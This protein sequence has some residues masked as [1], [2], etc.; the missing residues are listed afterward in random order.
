MFA[1]AHLGSGDEARRG[2]YRPGRRAKQRRA[3]RF[4]LRL[5]LEWL[6]DRVVPAFVGPVSTPIAAGTVGMVVA[7]F[8][9]DGKLDV[10][11]DNT[12][13]DQVDVMLGNGDGTFQPQVAYSAGTQAPTGLVAGDF[14]GDGHVDLGVIGGD[15]TTFTPVIHV[16]PGNGDGTFISN[17]NAFPQ[18]DTTPFGAGY[19]SATDPLSGTPL[20]GAVTVA[21]INHDGRLD[22]LA[23]N[24]TA[25]TVEDLLGNGDGTF[26][27]AVVHAATAGVLSVTAADLNHDGRLDL[28]LANPADSRDARELHHPARQR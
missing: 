3:T 22:V 13:L 4:G 24:P 12:S 21:D 1:R 6:E 16:L 26:Q 27:P 8:N 11:T 20:H 15:L 17:P 19:G 5:G 14:N 9:G 28:V 23:V 10:A 18:P 7:D 25:G 2:S